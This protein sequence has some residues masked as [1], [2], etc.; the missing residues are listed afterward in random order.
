ML[1]LQVVLPAQTTTLNPWPLINTLLTALVWYWGARLESQ[2]KQLR[3]ELHREPK[4]V[5]RDA[6][7]LR[8]DL[9][10]QSKTLE[11]GLQELR[12]SQD[13]LNY[14]LAGT[15]VLAVAP[16]LVEKVARLLGITP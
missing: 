3:G 6:K 4:G 14:W 2:I 11:E 13:R 1:S 9:H 5:H 16:T 7:R 8:R 12:R 15:A 10:T